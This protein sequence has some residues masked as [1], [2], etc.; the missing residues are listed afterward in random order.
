MTYPDILASTTEGVATPVS[1]PASSAESGIHTVPE[2]L[3]SLRSP[4]RDETYR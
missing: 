4:S 1:S 3:D 2:L